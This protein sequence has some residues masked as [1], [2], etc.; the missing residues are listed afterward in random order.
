MPQVAHIHDVRESF[1]GVTN[2]ATH[3][4]VHPL[5][6]LT[7]LLVSDCCQ[8]F[9]EN[10]FGRGELEHQKH[11][12]VLEKDTQEKTEI[13]LDALIGRIRSH[14]LDDHSKRPRQHKFFQHRP[15]GDLAGGISPVKSQLA[16]KRKRQSLHHATPLCAV[17]E[18]RV[19]HW[20]TCAH[21]GEE[22]V[23]RFDEK[24]GGKR[25]TLEGPP[26]GRVPLNVPDHGGPHDTDIDGRVVGE[27]EGNWCGVM[28]HVEIFLKVGVELEESISGLLRVMCCFVDVA[29]HCNLLDVVDFVVASAAFCG[30][31]DP[32]PCCKRSAGVLGVLV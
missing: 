18:C 10:V 21:L 24:R 20:L 29:K 17:A 8:Q 22:R 2:G 19:V 12:G 30:V 31:E 11:L 27:M 32:L 26:Y 15:V 13:H 1:D 25:R 23:A 16:V 28:K 14:Q 9:V 4:R 6:V 5:H 3:H 7:S